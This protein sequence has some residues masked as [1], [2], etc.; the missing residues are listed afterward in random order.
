MAFWLP[1]KIYYGY[2]LISHLRCFIWKG[3]GK[4]TLNKDSKIDHFQDY[5][6]TLSQIS[7]HGL[8]RTLSQNVLLLWP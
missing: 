8:L 1:F 5:L 6:I 3:E 7:T 4:I 2:V